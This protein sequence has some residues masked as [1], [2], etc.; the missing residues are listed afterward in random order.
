MPSPALK[1]DNELNTKAKVQPKQINF[2]QQATPVQ[3]SNDQANP[4]QQKDETI[5]ESGADDNATGAEEGAVGEENEVPAEEV[6][7]L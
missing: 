2:T 7:E 4:E 5:N 6:T 3:T 1:E